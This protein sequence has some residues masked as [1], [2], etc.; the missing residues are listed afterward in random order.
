MHAQKHSCRDRTSGRSI[1]RECRKDW[2]LY[3]WNGLCATVLACLICLSV[4][5]EY[6]AQMEVTD[7]HKISMDLSVG[8]DPIESMIKKAQFVEEGMKNPETYVTVLR[9]ESFLKILLGTNVRKYNMTYGEYLKMKNKEPWWIEPF[10]KRDD[11]YA[12]ELLSNKIGYKLSSKY[13]T[14]KLQVKDNDPE[15]AAAMTDSLCNILAKHLE[16]HRMTVNGAKMENA[17]IQRKEAGR[18]YREAQDAYSAF[19]Q[20][21]IGSSIEA[22]NTIIESLRKER[23]NAF[24]Q[25][26]DACLKYEH[27]KLSVSRNIPYFTVLYNSTVPT[28]PCNPIWVG[29]LMSFIFIAWLFTTWWI[30][31]KNSTLKNKEG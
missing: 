29:Y 15:V 22:D 25:Y 13:Y 20:S 19:A 11:A 26:N 7:E 24:K 14:I 28:E 12:R 2:K 23:D 17:L 5:K 21:H 30:L 31:Y 18:K 1:L 4:P 27:Y 9:S 10:L 3:V 6:A 16:N 8:L